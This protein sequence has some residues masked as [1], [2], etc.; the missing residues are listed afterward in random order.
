MKEK[1]DKVFVCF[2]FLLGFLCHNVKGQFTVSGSNSDGIYTNLTGVGGVFA[3]I[4]AT[5]QSGMSISVAVIASST[6]LEDGSI[7]LKGTAGQWASL[8]IYPTGTGNWTI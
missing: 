5:N 1:I 4:N 7:S 3:A 8:K 6:T 2:M